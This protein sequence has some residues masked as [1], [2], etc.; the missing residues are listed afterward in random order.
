M[1][2]GIKPDSAMAY[3]I[4]QVT[5]RYSLQLVADAT[6]TEHRSHIAAG[7]PELEADITLPRK[8]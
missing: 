1:V 8:L 7:T 2:Q 6:D 5:D 4:V 3:E